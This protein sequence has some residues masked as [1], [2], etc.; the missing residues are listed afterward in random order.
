MKIRPIQK[1]DNAQIYHLIRK[2][3]EEHQLNL[4]GTAYTDQSLSALTEFYQSEKD[5]QYFVIADENGKICGGAGIAPFSGKIC[6]LQKLYIAPEVRGQGWSKKLF[7]ECQNFA[8]GK[9]Q[10]IYLESHTNLATAL[11]L[12]PR[13]GFRPLPA[14][15]TGSQHSLMNVWMIKDL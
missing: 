11:K 1:Q 5:A 6:E 3:L 12:Y 8:Q 13:L 7:A 15:L 10:Q 4:P 2:V 9:Y 14:P